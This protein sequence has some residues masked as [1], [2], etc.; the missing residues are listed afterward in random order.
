MARSK[1]HHVGII[2]ADAERLAELMA[3]LGVEPGRRQ[4][5]AEYEAECVFSAGAGAAIEF[6]IPIGPKL[7]N[8][9]KGMGGLHHIALEV[10]DLDRSSDEL[11]SQGIELLERQA[12]D[13][14]PL[15]INFIPPAYTRGLIVELVEDKKPCQETPSQETQ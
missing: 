2:V 13:A 4:Y 12:V 7:A 9:N 14:G 11:R 3:L 8:F 1:L 6:V 5:V 10:E 15:R